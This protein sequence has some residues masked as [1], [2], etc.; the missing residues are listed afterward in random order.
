M[1]NARRLIAYYIAAGL[2]AA[3]AAAWYVYEATRV[4]EPS[5][6]F[7]AQAATIQ[8]GHIIH[9][10]AT[11][12]RS[13]DNIAAR[14][15]RASYEFKYAVDLLKARRDNL[16]RI[17]EAYPSLAFHEIDFLNDVLVLTEPLLTDSEL[18]PEHARALAIAVRHGLSA[19]DRAFT[20][21]SGFGLKTVESQSNQTSRFAT[22]TGI[23]FALLLATMLLIVVLVNRQRNVLVRHQ[24]MLEHE[25]RARTEELRRSEERFRGFA[26]SAS[27]ILWEMDENLR[28]TFFS[29]NIEQIAGRGI[30]ELIGL[31]RRQRAIP[32]EFITEREK[33]ARHMDDL[34]HHK[35]FRNFEYA[36]RRLDGEIRDLQVSGNPVFDDKGRFAGYRGASQDITERKRSERAL[37]AAYA[38]MEQRVEARTRE[39]AIAKEQAEK[40]NLAKSEFLAHMS[41]ELRTP[42]NSIIGFSEIMTSQMMGPVGNPKYLE[43]IG[44]IKT[45]GQHLLAIIQDILDI[46]K[47]EAGELILTEEDV[48]C[49]SLL[50]DAI[51]MIQDQAFR[52]KLE[53]SLELPPALPRVRADPLRLKQ[54]LLNLLSNALK[55]TNGPGSIRLEAAQEV[56]GGIVIK[57]SDTGIGIAAENLEKVLE[58]FGQIR[59]TTSRSHE[60]TGLGLSLSRSFTELHGGTLTIE[61]ELGCGTTVSVRLPSERIAAAAY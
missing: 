44:D 56:D 17:Q 38:H 14:R 61:S 8:I 15:T 42:L 55:F 13:I 40:A 46:S 2:V 51:R 49:A 23:A 1:K 34:T 30:S 31:E 7:E 52:S 60:G 19:F 6:A 29:E 57:V 22:S 26:E 12:D 3:G 27:D 43:Y 54:I 18:G 45:S 48:D 16:L 41:H 21:L 10:L 37:Q 4:V 59:E 33:W 58:P 32:E 35:P 11:L 39:L 53:L 9:D 47:I 50:T 36:I 25:V 28:F 5:L 20:R 24:Q